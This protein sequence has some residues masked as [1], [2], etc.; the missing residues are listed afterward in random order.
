M[1][2]SHVI[3]ILIAFAAILSSRMAKGPEIASNYIVVG[4]DKIIK[5][6]DSIERIDFD[7]EFMFIGI[8][9]DTIRIDSIRYIRKLETYK[10]K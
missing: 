2:F 1:R 3:L 4:S 10:L 6:L 9:G 8:H 5:Q 7:V